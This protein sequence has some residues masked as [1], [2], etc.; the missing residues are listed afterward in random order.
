MRARLLLGTLLAILV[1]AGFWFLVISPIIDNTN[2]IAAQTESEQQREAALTAERNELLR[3]QEAELQYIDAVGE[4]EASIPASPSQSELINALETLATES[5]VTWNGA[6]F[7]TPAPNDEG[8]Y[9]EIQTTVSVT[10]QY[11]EL[12]GYLYGMEDL[13]RLIRLDSAAF[14]PAVEDNTVELTVTIQA[15]AF[16][17]GDIAAPVVD[18]PGGDLGTGGDGMSDADPPTDDATSDTEDAVD[19]AEGASAETNGG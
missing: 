17:T 4:L 2:E 16:T 13:D 10:G 7:G 18:V 5:A 6:S 9:N 15:T 1:A 8:G 11:F 14:S 12:L 19:E 3:I